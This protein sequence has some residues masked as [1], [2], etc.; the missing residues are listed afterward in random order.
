M[1][2][3]TRNDTTN[4]IAD[5]NI[6]NAADLDG[7]FD[8]VQ[9]A[10]DAT[11]GHTHDGTVGEGAPI[12][13][14]GPTQDVVVTATVIRPKTDNTVDLGT[15]TLEFKDLY[16][17]GTAN[18]DSL[19]ADTADINGGTIDGAVIGGSSAA[20][21]TFT[22]ATATTGNITTVNATTV[23]TTN[24]EVTN[25]KA[26]DGTA[27]ATIADS[28]GVMTIASAVLTTADINGGTV[29][30]TTIGGASAAAG[31][32]TTAT[33]TT[34]NITTV[35]ATTV[36]TTNIEV[37]NIKAK[38]G[39]SAGSIADSTGVVTLASSVLTT[40][41]INGG[42]IDGA[43]IGGSSAAAGTFTTV[44]ASGDLTIADKIVHSGDTNTSIRFPA[45]D[46]VTVE[47]SGAERLRVDS[48]GNVGIGTTSPTA[49]L[50]VGS[51]SSSSGDVHL[52]TSKTTFELTP[53]N[54]DA[55]GMDINVGF[56]AGGQGP[57]K[58]SIGGTERAR[59]DSSGNLLVGTTSQYG[60]QKLSLNGGIA[61][62]GRSAATPGLSEKGD[63]NTGVF[64]P[65]ADSLGFS[66]GGTERARIDSSGNLLVGTTTSP[67]GSGRI[68]SNGGIYLGGTAA[69]NN[70]DDYE[71]GTWTPTVLYNGS[72]TGQ[73]YTHQVG[74]YTKVGR[75]VHYQAYVQVATNSSAVGSLTVGGL[76]FTSSTATNVATTGSAGMDNASAN[77]DQPVGRVAVNTTQVQILA[78]NGT[79]NWS[80]LDNSVRGSNFRV[81]V[82][83]HYITD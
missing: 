24:I 26:K 13:V 25:I 73:T 2:G 78:G 62:D 20:A 19:V 35:N 49:D 81:Y 41:D 3:Y 47:T 76:P 42:T 52:R 37:T 51:A 27:S 55:G 5:G 60:S 46:T 56:V 79:N 7:E 71:E 65:A 22:T 32:F 57:L 63:D 70:L 50:S 54:S 12:E 14:L 45:A 53:S 23:D 74:T 75:V 44:T 11:T 17:D 8:A 6:I 1:T 58:F 29:D 34:G 64:W 15:S 31:T 83:G 72:D 80:A 61:I 59:I 18:I 39:T 38:D 77:L 40:T 48:S 33:A 82:A 69:A 21:G 66:T 16:I 4:N 68:V 10:F 43:V 30:G 28:T 36:D 9:A 67:S